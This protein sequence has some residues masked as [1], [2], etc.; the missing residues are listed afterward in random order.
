MGQ[1]PLDHPFKRLK[2]DIYYDVPVLKHL[3]STMKQEGWTP[4]EILQSIED[5]KVVL[6]EDDEY[7]YKKKYKE[8]QKGDLN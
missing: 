5:Y 2:G 1:L 7:K 3:F 4:Q 6:E 8:F